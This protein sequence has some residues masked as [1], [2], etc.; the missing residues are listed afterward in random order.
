[1]CDFFIQA[2]WPIGP[3]LIL[4]TASLRDWDY[5]YSPLEGMLVHRRVTPA[6][7]LL[8]PI[9]VE[10]GTLRVKCKVQFMCEG[11]F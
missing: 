10:R 7:L 2:K 1:M 3:E 11:F 9:K 5:L 8:I 6:L 4:V